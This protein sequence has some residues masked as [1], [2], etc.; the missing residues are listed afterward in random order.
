MGQDYITQKKKKY[1]KEYLEMLRWRYEGL[2]EEQILR[3]Y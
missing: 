3:K 1:L 2:N